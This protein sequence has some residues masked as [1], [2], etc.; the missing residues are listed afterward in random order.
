MKRFAILLGACAIAAAALP[1]AAEQRATLFCNSASRGPVE[2]LKTMVSAQARVQ[3]DTVCGGTADGVGRVNRGEPVDIII[4]N[5]DVIQEMEARGLVKTRIDVG[6]SDVGVAVAEQAPPPVMQSKE[7]FIAFLRNTP[8][9]G[10]TTGASGVHLAKVID[11]L[12]LS[13]VMKPK[14]TVVSGG[15]AAKLLRDGKVAAAVQQIGELRADGAKNVVALPEA[16]QM[17]TMLA[18]AIMNNAPHAD[19]AAAVVRVM[20][21]PQSVPVY[22]RWGLVS[23]LKNQK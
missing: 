4:T 21:S 13:E 5:R 14:T 11:A 1:M 20:T 3:L 23:V 16:V 7:D 10:Y 6:I 18:I 22:Q 9:L 19:A 15:N 2:E 12:G 17:H 8:S